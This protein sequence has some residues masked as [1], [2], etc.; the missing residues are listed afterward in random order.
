ML[1]GRLDIRSST[2]GVFIALT[3]PATADADGARTAR[4]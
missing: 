1:G 4:T 3:F 2:D